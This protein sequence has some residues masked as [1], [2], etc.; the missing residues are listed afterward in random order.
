MM[1]P[2]G[3]DIGKVFIALD[4]YFYQQIVIAGDRV[5]LRDTVDLH[6]LIGDSLNL[7]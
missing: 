2:L 1:N 3:H 4:V 6:N 7:A 5:D